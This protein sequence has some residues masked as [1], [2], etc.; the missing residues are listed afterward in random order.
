MLPN[1]SPPGLPNQPLSVTK[2][3]EN[4]EQRLQAEDIK[5]S[6]V[7]NL[8]I[9]SYLTKAIEDAMIKRVGILKFPLLLIDIPLILAVLIVNLERIVYT[10]VI[11][12]LVAH[13][14]FDIAIITNGIKKVFNIGQ[15]PV[16]SEDDEEEIY[17]E[18]PSGKAFQTIRYILR[19]LWGVL[20]LGIFLPVWPLILLYNIFIELFLIG[21]LYYIFIT[22]HF[23]DWWG[24]LLSYTIFAT[25]TFIIA[26]ISVPAFLRT[27]TYLKYLFSIER[28]SWREINNE[29]KLA[30][31]SIYLRIQNNKLDVLGRLGSRYEPVEKV[32]GGL[33]YLFLKTIY[34]V[35][36]RVFD[37]RKKRVK[38]L[39]G[40][41]DQTVKSAQGELSNE[42]ETYEKTVS[43]M[44]PSELFKTALALI[45]TFA[46]S[47]LLLLRGSSGE[48]ITAPIIFSFLDQARGLSMWI[49]YQGSNLGYYEFLAQKAGFLPEI[50][51]YAAIG[52]DTIL[53]YFFQA[54][55]YVLPVYLKFFTDYYLFYFSNIIAR[56][57]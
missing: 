57:V 18:T 55:Y 47:A 42:L 38:Q 15:N 50:L 30:F 44:T 24:G 13:I 22:Y 26:S 51:R 56:I 48:G 35:K 54:Y 3:P 5:I 16:Y 14:K 32:E 34:G 43:L 25:V 52:L 33:Y 31:L 11:E 23:P 1:E 36:D 45:L 4:D 29:A 12:Y 10:Y 17:E 53:H 8:G 28:K 37:L 46:L 7:E 39:M 6:Y 19:F 2:Q 27:F 20:I 9:I 41:L 49:N 40:D 21:F